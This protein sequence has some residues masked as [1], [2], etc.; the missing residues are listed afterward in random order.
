MNTRLTQEQ[1]EQYWSEGYVA[2]LHAI[3]ELEGPCA[4]AKIR[5]GAEPHVQLGG[6]CPI[7]QVS[8]GRPLGE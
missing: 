1:I 3:S 6:I 8:S 4:G 7:A 2:Q 5:A